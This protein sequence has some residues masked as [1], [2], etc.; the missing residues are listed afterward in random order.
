MSSLENNK[1]FGALLG[2]G[3][4]VMAAGV[5]SD[6]VF[7]SHAP[8]KAGYELA[9]LDPAAA[10]GGGAPAAAAVPLP[11]LLA[12]ANPE[13]GQNLVKA[14]AACHA[15]EKGGPN[16]VGPGL[17]GVVGH[18]KAT[19]PGFSYS[20]A[21][22]GKGG[23]W[24]FDDLDHFIA[25]PRGFAAGTKMAFAGEKDPARR[26]D[27]LAYLRTLSDAPVA[28]PAAPAQTGAAPATPQPAPAQS[29]PHK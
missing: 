23:V 21:L 14:C 5:V 15:F 24:T 7:A 19:H 26:A 20:D 16:K 11:V 29:Q 28:L 12:S 17:Y 6:L 18:E 4:F 1:I 22:K 2:T 3:L 9:A 27:I 25:N 10:G 8:A 13:R